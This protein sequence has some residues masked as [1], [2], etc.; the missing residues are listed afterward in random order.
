VYPRDVIEHLRSDPLLRERFGAALPPD[1]SGF[2]TVPAAYADPAEPEL[3]RWLVSEGWRA[4]RAV[5]RYVFFLKHTIQTFES[6]RAYFDEANTL[7]RH[8]D[9][10]RAVQTSVDEMLFIANHLYVL[11]SH[12]VGGDVLECGAFKG[13][14]SCCL[15]W[16]CSFLGRKLLVADSFAGL[17][18]DRSQSYYQPGEF[19][20]TIAEVRANLACLGRIEST[21]L[22]PG[23]FA[24]SLAGFD[25]PLA[26]IW[27]DVDLYGSVM[28][29]LSNAFRCLDPR[30]VLFSNEFARESISPAHQVLAAGL[31]PKA[32]ADYFAEHRIAHVAR[33]LTDWT[34]LV[35]PFAEPGSKP[36]LSVPRFSTLLRQLRSDRRQ[37]SSPPA[38]AGLLGRLKQSIRGTWPAGVGSEAAAGY[39]DLVNGEGA[40]DGVFRSRR[41]SLRIVGWAVDSFSGP[42]ARA[43]GG[44]YVTLG[45]EKFRADYGLRR[46]DVADAH[47]E[48]G[49]ICSGFEAVIPAD[50][51]PV[52]SSTLGL[53]VMSHDGS[54]SRRARVAFKLVVE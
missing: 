41:T 12:G 5:R 54:E 8:P 48:D 10:A 45:A 3:E 27:I 19:T 17:P 53:L 6:I 1:G 21:E 36:A 30:G 42:K 49:V 31:V 11:D 15:S 40:S 23:F 28:D 26:A 2:H 47:Q 16:T 43:S 51:V 29:V 33:H 22:V 52:G 4:S 44:V 34:A 32:F 18:E 35:V 24:A 50:R 38:P 14:S 9:D 20:G 37:A 46:E 25:R 13:F 7:S 39:I